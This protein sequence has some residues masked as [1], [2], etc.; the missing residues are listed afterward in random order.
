M[1]VQLPGH[2]FNILSSLFKKKITC[3]ILYYPQL[4]AYM[5]TDIISNRLCT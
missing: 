2:V 5:D 1:A 3:E 4:T